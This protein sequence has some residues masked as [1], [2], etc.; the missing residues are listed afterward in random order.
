VFIEKTYIGTKI[1]KA[2]PMDELEFASKHGSGDRDTLDVDPTGLAR[3]GYKVT[4]PDGYVSWSPKDVFEAAY[5]EIAD[6]E[7][8]LM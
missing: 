3:L 7:K 6:N 8:A 1:I 2:I 5:R 4:Y